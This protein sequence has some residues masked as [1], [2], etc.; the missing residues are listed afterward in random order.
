MVFAC[1]AA[2][3]VGRRIVSE[4]IIHIVQQSAINADDTLQKAVREQTK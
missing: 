2:R 3:T 1:G 4:N